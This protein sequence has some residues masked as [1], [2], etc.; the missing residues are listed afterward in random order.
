LQ[1]LKTNSKEDTPMKKKWIYFTAAG[2]LCAGTQLMAADLTLVTDRYDTASQMLLANEIN[3]SGE[4]F[5]EALGYNLDLLDPFIP[6]SPDQT[7]YT[8]GIENYEYSRYQL[9]TIISRSGLGLH[10]MWAPLIMKGA[11]AEPVG[12]DG[13]M[14][15]GVANGFNEDDELVKNIKMFSHLSGHRPPGNPWP[16]FAEFVSG[17]P[18]LPQAIDPVNFAWNDFSTLRWDRNK[19]RK[20]LNPA[21]MGQSLMKQYLWAS[22]MLSAFH[23]V[24]DNGIDADGVVSPDFAGSPFFNPDNNV[25]FGGNS[26]DGF[27]GMVLT[28][29]SINKVAFMT[30]KLAYN[31]SALGAIDL[32]SYN[33]ANGIQYFPAK[34]KVTESLVHPT[35]PPKAS[36]FRVIDKRSQLFDQASLLW[37]ISSFVNMM[38][39]TDN[40]DSAHLAYHDVFDGSPF[41]PAMSQSGSPGPYD[42]MKGTARAI[43]LNLLAMHYD[44]AHKTFVDTAS[45]KRGKVKREEKISTL[46]AAYLIVALEPFIEEF[47]NTPLGP[48]AR[49]V[50]IEQAM[51]LMDHLN[52]GNDGYGKNIDVDEDSNRPT[53]AKRVGDQAAAVRA[54]YVANRVTGMAKFKQAGARAYR[55]LI[56]RFYLPGLT[57]FRTNLHKGKA[58]YTPLNFALISGALREASLQ[59]GFA[60][61]APIYTAFF[62]AI[63]NKMQLSEGASTGETGADSDGDGIPYIPEQPDGLPPVFASKAILKLGR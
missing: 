10:M 3:E 15:G 30:Q 5:A 33:P 1:H 20:V 11:A 2:A 18:H 53:R 34:V 19:M 40:S 49:Q 26:L 21:A 4:P 16:Q 63:G 25:F 57:V 54:L 17:D 13:S 47:A 44:A 12:F 31:G 9:G 55:A 51:F 8:L 59:G 35:L 56:D 50:V 7:A 28:A 58:K 52:D 6:A 45:I 32:A 48:K 61:A 38:D 24:D 36:G 14:T 22:D 43:F 41:P 23:D 27:V 39:P 60:D 29:E 46:D 62:Q 37:G 42:L